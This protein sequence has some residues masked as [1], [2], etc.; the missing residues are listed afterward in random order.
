[1]YENIWLGERKKRSDRSRERSLSVFCEREAL[2]C[3]AVDGAIK[4]LSPHLGFAT[5]L[6]GVKGNYYHPHFRNDE[7]E[8]D[9][10]CG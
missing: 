7:R 10:L 6:H 1:M 2:A 3:F 8:A 9:V 5:N 4:K